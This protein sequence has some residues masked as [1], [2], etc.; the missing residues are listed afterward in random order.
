MGKIPI[1]YKAYDNG[2]KVP[3]GICLSVGLSAL[4]YGLTSA[5][6]SVL[7][8][9]VVCLVL[10][11]LFKYLNYVRA[12]EEAEEDYNDTLI[13]CKKEVDAVL[14]N[15]TL[16]NQEKINKLINLAE[17]GNFYANAFLRELAVK[18]KENE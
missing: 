8:L 6:V 5:E 2:F 11:F 16:S 4:I 9:G 10:F 14:E 13:Q 15:Q 18:I 12:K 17:R 1:S 7:V 3:M